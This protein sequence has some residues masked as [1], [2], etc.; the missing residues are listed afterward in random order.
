MNERFYQSL[1]KLCFYV[2]AKIGAKKESYQL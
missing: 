1:Y 2:S